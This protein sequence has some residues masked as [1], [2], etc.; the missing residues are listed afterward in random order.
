MNNWHELLMLMLDFLE[1][2]ASW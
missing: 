1:Q 2:Q